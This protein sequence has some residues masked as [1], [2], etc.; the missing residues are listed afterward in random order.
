MPYFSRHS[1]CKFLFFVVHVIIHFMLELLFVPIF[2][3]IIFSIFVFLTFLHLFFLGFLV[4]SHLHC[5]QVH[6]DVSFHLQFFI[7]CICVLVLLWGF[8][9]FYWGS[10]CWSFQLFILMV[11][12]EGPFS[13]S[14]L[15]LHVCVAFFFAFIWCHLLLCYYFFCSSFKKINVVFLILVF[16]FLTLPK[17]LVLLM[18]LTF[19]LSFQSFSFPSSYLHLILD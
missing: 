1:T 7:F 4:F 2:C 8:F 10:Y 18:F 13:F 9:Q 16:L 17:I 11:F 14:L 19:L 15:C 5:F 12:F 6:F 3:V